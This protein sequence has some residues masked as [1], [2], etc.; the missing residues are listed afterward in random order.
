MY[1]NPK[2]RFLVCVLQEEAHEARTWIVECDSEADAVQ[3]A[4]ALDGGWSGKELD[5]SG[6]LELAA[7]YCTVLSVDPV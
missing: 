3:L 6:M 5:T 4:F 7:C 2:Y 1:E